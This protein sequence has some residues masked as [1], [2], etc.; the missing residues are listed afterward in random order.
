M[1]KEINTIKPYEIGQVVK[2]DKVERKILEI[3]NN[4]NNNVLVEVEII[5][6]YGELKKVKQWYTIESVELI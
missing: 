2:I 3:D 1:A 5:D 4:N 6:L